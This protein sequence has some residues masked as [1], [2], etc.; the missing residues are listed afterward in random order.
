MSDELELRAIP[1]EWYYHEIEM[2][3]KMEAEI[4]QLRAR[5]SELESLRPSVAEIERDE[6]IERAKQCERTTPE[7]RKYHRGHEI[8]PAQLADGSTIY[9]TLKVIRS[10]SSEEFARE[11]IDQD[12][13]DPFIDN[14]DEVC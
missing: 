4:T 2:V 1:R 5:V 8:R 9:T 7:E 12:I 3:R 13:D 14:P 6:A 10:T 11:L